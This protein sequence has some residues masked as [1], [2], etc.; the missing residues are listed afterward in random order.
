MTGG[1]SDSPRGSVK[2]I[3]N[4][5]GWMSLPPSFLPTSTTSYSSP[6]PPKRTFSSSNMHQKRRCSGARNDL[7]GWVNPK[8]EGPEIFFFF[9]WA[10]LGYL[11]NLERWKEVTVVKTCK[12]LS[13]IFTWHSW[14]WKVSRLVHHNNI[15]QLASMLIPIITSEISKFFPP[16]FGC[17]SVNLLVARL[18][19]CVHSVFRTKM[20]WV[21]PEDLKNFLSALYSSLKHWQSFKAKCIWKM[22]RS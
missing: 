22:N 4:G 10:H 21:Y 20:R 5:W 3:S 9:F 14:C 2:R 13:F 17:R 19:F 18:L 16:L 1:T 15:I 7:T 8:W 6:S 11:V 12:W